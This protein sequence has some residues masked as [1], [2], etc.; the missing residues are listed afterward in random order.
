YMGAAMYGKGDYLNAIKKCGELRENV[1]KSPYVPDSKL[2]EALSHYRRKEYVE[3]ETMFKEVDA[4]YPD[5]KRKWELYYYGAECEV[6]LR[7]YPAAVVW[8]GR[9][10]KEAK[11][12]RQKADALRH[13]GDALYASAKYDSAQVVYAECLKA[14]EGGSRRLDLALK[15]GDALEQ[16]KRYDEALKFYEKWKPFAVAESRE[17][18]L[19][20]R[21]YG[22]LAVLGRASEA[23][24]G[25]RA[26]VTQYPHT[27]IA[28]EAQFRLG[29]LYESQMGDFDSAGREYDLLKQEPG[30]SEFQVQAS[31]RSGNLAT[32]K[33]YRQTLLGDSTQARARAAFLLAEIYYFQIEKADSAMIQYSLVER[34]FPESP[35]APK[36]AF[37]RLWINTHDR[38]DTA[39]AAALT[40]SIAN[41]YRKT[42]YAESALYL[43]RRWSGRTDE[44]TALLD[45]MIAHPDTA[46]ARERAADLL[47]PTITPAAIDSMRTP[48]AIEQI[49]PAEAARR[50]S[51]AAYTRALYKAQ[52]EGKPPPPP[53]P[54]RSP[55][56]ADTAQTKPPPRLPFEPDDADTTDTETE[57]PA[58]APSQ[59]SAPADTTSSPSIGPSR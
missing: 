48:Q 27:P 19:S 55:A 11:K 7:N 24:S 8:Y 36:A 2:V 47:E 29:Y 3:A 20:I 15:R 39:A 31:R 4:Q 5:F 6:G 9:A 22:I 54:P 49:T 37:A 57:T 30:S 12:K 58:P 10:V 17:G 53:L 50:D 25:Y 32:I 1:P 26:L 42:R 33:K 46:L 16:L 45:S 40:D 18:E 14:E 52:R 21:I 23:A 38:A 41:R 51:L 43:W 13:T 28:Y 35:Y 44:R 59:P 56:V 34:D